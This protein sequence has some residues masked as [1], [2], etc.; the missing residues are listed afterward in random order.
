MTLPMPCHVYAMPCHAIIA[1]SP[2][3]TL[4]AMLRHADER[5][6]PLMLILIR[7]RHDAMLSLLMPLLLLRHIMPC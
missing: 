3:V 6:H 1:F 5:Q 2:S 7:C 4:F